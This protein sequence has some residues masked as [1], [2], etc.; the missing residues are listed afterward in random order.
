MKRKSARVRYAPPSV[1]EDCVPLRLL[2]RL[3]RLDRQQQQLVE[4][5]IAGFERGVR[6]QREEEA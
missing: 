2:A 3:A 6:R 4:L 5:M 1:P